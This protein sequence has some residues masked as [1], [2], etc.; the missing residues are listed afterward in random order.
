MEGFQA[1]D[2]HNPLPHIGPSATALNWVYGK[3]VPL[4]ANLATELRELQVLGGLEWQQTR[5]SQ[6]DSEHGGITRSVY[7]VKAATRL[8][9]MTN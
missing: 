2:R 6:S 4:S 3:T 1:E 9:E 8:A 5:P 7:L